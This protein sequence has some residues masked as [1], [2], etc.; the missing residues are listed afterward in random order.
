MISLLLSPQVSDAVPP[1]I[2]LAG[3]TLTIDGV[4]ID[5]DAIP[6]GGALA[7]EDSGSLW[8]VGYIR[9]AGDGAVTVPLLLPIP[10]DAPEALRFPAPVEVAADGPVNLG[11]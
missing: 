10:V 4:P 5:L 7:A 11:S 3:G 9:R 2:A 6:P 8:V 1:A